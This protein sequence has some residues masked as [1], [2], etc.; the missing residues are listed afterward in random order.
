MR[1]LPW[2]RFG[3]AVGIAIGMFTLSRLYG[4][5]AAGVALAIAVFS[6]IRGAMD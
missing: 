5:E 2:T 1:P 3:L 6:Y 4:L